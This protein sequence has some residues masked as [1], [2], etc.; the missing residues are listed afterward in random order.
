MLPVI[1]SRKELQIDLEGATDLDV[2]AVQSL[3]CAAAKPKKAG[4]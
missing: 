4:P 1:A 2:M 3:I